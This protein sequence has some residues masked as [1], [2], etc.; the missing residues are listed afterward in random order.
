MCTLF[1]VSQAGEEAT[2]ADVADYSDRAHRYQSRSGLQDGGPVQELS[3]RPVASILAEEANER[4]EQSPSE[5][6]SS[7]RSP[8]LG[9]HKSRVLPT[10]SHAPH[11]PPP[12][13]PLLTLVEEQLFGGAA[14]AA[15]S[16]EDEELRSSAT[17]DPRLPELSGPAG[18]RGRPRRPK[19]LSLPPEYAGRTLERRPLDDIEG[20]ETAKG[21]A[22]EHNAAI[23]E[24]RSELQQSTQLPPKMGSKTTRESGLD[25]SPSQESSEPESLAS[26]H[27]PAVRALLRSRRNVSPHQVAPVPRTN[28]ERDRDR[29]LAFESSYEA[30][31]NP[32]LLRILECGLPGG[33]GD[34][35]AVELFGANA[36]NA[37]A[38]DAGEATDLDAEQLPLDEVES[39]SASGGRTTAL[40]GNR[41]FKRGLHFR[42]GKQYACIDLD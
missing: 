6:S 1:H 15:E 24:Q 20:P 29:T 22:T 19:H 5:A 17:E 38:V 7:A 41:Q 13:D 31:Y 21:T 28:A 23:G 35:S 16:V 39:T 18:R 12:R 37:A 26:L 30:V 42:R 36:A 9:E 33:A 8:R 34:A 10:G 14:S 27:E 4:E 11:P 40:R 2:N 25:S 3:S 32:Q